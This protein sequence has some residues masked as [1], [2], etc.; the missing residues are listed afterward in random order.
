MGEIDLSDDAVQAAAEAL[1][2][3]NSASSEYHCDSWTWREFEHAAR[4]ALTAALPHLREQI[5]NG[6]GR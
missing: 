2:R 3:D 1:L 4:V 6:Q 5:E